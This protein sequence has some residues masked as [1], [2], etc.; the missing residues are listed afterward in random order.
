M[1]LALGVPAV[2]YVHAFR[3]VV[4]ALPHFRPNRLPSEGDLVGLEHL[5]SV[6]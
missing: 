2:D 4:V 6:H 5:A 1:E 3:S